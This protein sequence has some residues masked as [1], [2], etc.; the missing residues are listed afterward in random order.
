[1]SNHSL[2]WRK[3][4][5]IR[6]IKLPRISVFHAIRNLRLRLG[7]RWQRSYPQT[8]DFRNARRD[9]ILLIFIAAL[10]AWS[11]NE[12]WKEEQVKARVDAESEAESYRKAIYDCIT[13]SDMG[14]RS[15]IY[16]QQWRVG[17]GCS[18]ERVEG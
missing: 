1:M 14:V 13:A 11:M 2:G 10:W 5:E 12:S 17:F 7:L 15:A 3:A 16:F 9:A 8:A 18:M 6:G 4:N